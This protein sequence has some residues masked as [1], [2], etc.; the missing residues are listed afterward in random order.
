[1][2]GPTLRQRLALA[3]AAALLPLLFRRTRFDVFV[4]PRGSIRLNAR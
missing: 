2:S 3:L 4:G 1:M